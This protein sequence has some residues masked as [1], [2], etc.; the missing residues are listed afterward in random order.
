MQPF[1]IEDAVM[2]DMSLVL[3]IVLSAYFHTGYHRFGSGLI[4]VPLLALSHPLQFAVRSC[5]RSISR[6][7]SFWAAL[8]GS[9]RLGRDQGASCRSA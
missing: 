3:C 5:L 7:R 4:A 2:A 6:R 1:S 9:G 8:T